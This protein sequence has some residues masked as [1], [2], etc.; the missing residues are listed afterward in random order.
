VRDSGSLSGPFGLLFAA[1]GLFSCVSLDDVQ[2][3]FCAEHPGVC[4]GDSGA[5]DSGVGSDAG[6]ADAATPADA[7]PTQDSGAS[8]SGAPPDAGDPSDGGSRA[9]AGLDGGVQD[10]GPPQCTTVALVSYYC[11]SPINFAIADLHNTGTPDIVALEFDNADAVIYDNDGTG[12]F[13][14]ARKIYGLTDAGLPYGL[15]LAD[16]NLDGTIDLAFTLGDTLFVMAN[17]GGAVFAPP[18]RYAAG[19]N[20][21]LAAGDFDGDGWPDLAISDSAN[22]SVILYLNAHDGGFK[23]AKVYDAG[24]LQPVGMNAGCFDPSGRLDLFGTDFETEF[25]TL[26]NNGAGAFKVG[27]L[28]SWNVPGWPAFGD[29][30]GNGKLDLVVSAVNG[31]QTLPGSGSGAFSQV[32]GTVVT[33]SFGIERSSVFDVNGDGK[34]DIVFGGALPDGGGAVAAFLGHGDGTFDGELDIAASGS[35]QSLFLALSSDLNGNG[36][37][38]IVA[39]QSLGNAITVALDPCQLPAVKTLACV[40]LGQRCDG[41]TPCCSL[42]ACVAGTCP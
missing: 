21:Y 13:A 10:A 24:T 31:F 9:D 22:N 15:A 19:D 6:S 11:Q 18:A 26:L 41:G 33:T 20:P 34:V 38:D 27:T 14:A 37:P 8:D 2:G 7:G 36:I 42:G 30:T 4:S 28:Q 16:F 40:P 3:Q 39:S 23:P 1:L 32:G 12:T 17:K 29:F 35:N 25:G 5:L